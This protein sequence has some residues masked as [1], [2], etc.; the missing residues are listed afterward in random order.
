MRSRR[1]A[2][3]GRSNQMIDNAK[4]TGNSLFEATPTRSSRPCK[5]ER[6]ARSIRIAVI[7][8]GVVV[9]SLV[10]ACGSPGEEATVET[11]LPAREITPAGCLTQDLCPTWGCLAGTIIG[12]NSW[13]RGMGEANFL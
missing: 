13:L 12:A 11:R 6:L 7:A 9:C 8:S 1:A 4:V 2:Q 10:G 5:G 3:S